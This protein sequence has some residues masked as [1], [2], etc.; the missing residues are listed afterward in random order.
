MRRRR[1]YTV[2]SMSYR[3]YWVWRI[4]SATL[5]YKGGTIEFIIGPIG[6]RK[7]PGPVSIGLIIGP[8][9]AR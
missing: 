8:V 7:L 1:G 9:S 6:T 2:T 3:W 5:H 4:Y